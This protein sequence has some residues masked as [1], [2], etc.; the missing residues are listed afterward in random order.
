MKAAKIQP[1]LTGDEFGDSSKHIGRGE[2]KETWTSY[3][4]G[5]N[6][7]FGQENSG[8]GSQ[9]SIVYS[10]SGGESNDNCLFDETGTNKYSM[11]IVKTGG[12]NHH[13]ISLGTRYSYQ[14]AKQSILLR[15][16]HQLQHGTDTKIMSSF[17]PSFLLRQLSENKKSLTPHTFFGKG[18]CLIADISGFVKLCG[19][20]SALGV[21][22]IDDLR[23]C[24]NRFIGDLVETVYMRG[25]D[26]M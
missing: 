15:R 22:G 2:Y 21:N 25:G 20:L 18:A 19:R 4:D 23:K 16:A 12:H 9:D 26:G 1:L 8:L 11:G 7:S 3:D 5:R 17:C 10:S 6:F 24:T 13:H 14:E